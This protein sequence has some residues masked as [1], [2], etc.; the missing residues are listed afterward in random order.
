LVLAQQRHYLFIHIVDYPQGEQAITTQAQCGL[1]GA[2]GCKYRPMVL[3]FHDRTPSAL[4]ALNFSTV[5]K[6][7]TVF[8]L[9]VTLTAA[10]ITYSVGSN[11]T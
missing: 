8:L 10:V 9:S 1:V 2:N 7:K 4:T 3:S 6:F 11:P 5:H